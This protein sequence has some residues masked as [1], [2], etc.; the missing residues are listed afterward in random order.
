M[1]TFLARR[2]FDS[3]K[4]KGQIAQ[5]VCGVIQADTQSVAR[6]CF[7]SH[8]KGKFEF[9]LTVGKDEG[10]D[11]C[12][13]RLTASEVPP[14]VVGIN[15]DPKAGIDQDDDV[16]DSDPE[17]P[18]EDAALGVDLCKP[19][20]DVLQE[21]TRVWFKLAP[22]DETYVVGDIKKVKFTS[23]GVVYDIWEDTYGSWRYAKHEAVLTRAPRGQVRRKRHAKKVRR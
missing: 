3:G 23:T 19:N 12:K 17:D 20:V 10:V 8:I 7:A 4:R 22:W 18:V 1:E 21:G 5:N 11:A 13:P 2:I 6:V 14:T 9:T 15:P 16:P